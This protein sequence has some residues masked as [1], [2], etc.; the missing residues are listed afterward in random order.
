[1]TYRKTYDV[2]R[3]T[4]DDH[5]NAHFNMIDYAING[6]NPRRDA[7]TVQLLNAWLLRPRQDFY[8]DVTRLVQVCGDH[9]CQPVPVELRPA[10]D[11]LWQR[12]PFQLTGGGD[13]FIESAGVDYI[14][15]YWM[16]RYY[17]LP[18]L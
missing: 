10:T 2:L 4:T 15:P 13:G 17:G 9:A 11:F 18:V 5:Q 12:N 7:E 1:M 3:N 8:T 14:L 6:P 16:A